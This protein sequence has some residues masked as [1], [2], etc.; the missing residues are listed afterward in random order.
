M[1]RREGLEARYDAMA[2]NVAERAYGDPLGRRLA[3][4][5][6]Q[7]RLMAR[8]IRETIVAIRSRPDS[9]RTTTRRSE[10]ATLWHRRRQLRADARQLRLLVAQRALH[11][12]LWAAE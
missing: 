12:R 11:D 9:P 3:E 1:N 10:V 8:L 4:A 5:E 2:P 7:A 6:G